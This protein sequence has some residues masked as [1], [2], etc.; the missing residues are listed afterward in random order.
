MKK[1]IGF[2]TIEI[3]LV[4]GKFVSKQGGKMFCGILHED[5]TMF[6]HG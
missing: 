3:N 6:I 2:D 1:T 4:F 5:E